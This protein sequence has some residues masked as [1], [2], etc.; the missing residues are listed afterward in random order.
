M[1][2]LA[3]KTSVALFGALHVD[4]RFHR[5]FTSRHMSNGSTC[6]FDV[7]KIDVFL[8]YVSASVKVI[9]D[10]LSQL[11]THPFMGTLVVCRNWAGLRI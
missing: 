11:T 4:R 10:D 1:A 8:R 6:W 5:C 9:Q 2:A 7:A 3:S